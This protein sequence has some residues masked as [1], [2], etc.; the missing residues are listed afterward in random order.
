MAST[1]SSPPALRAVRTLVARGGGTHYLQQRPRRLAE[2]VAWLLRIPSRRSLKGRCEQHAHAPPIGCTGLG[3]CRATMAMRGLTVFISDLRNCS[4][5]E[6][7]EK[8]VE[9]EMAHIRSKFR[10]D[11]NMNGYNRKKYVWK[12]LYMYMLGY[13]VDFGH[14]EAV[15]LISSQRYSEKSVGYAWCALMLREGDA[16]LRLFINSIRVDLISRNDN[17]ACLALNA[18]CNVGGEE[19]A[20]TLSSNVIELLTN[21][22]TKTYVRKK[23]ALTTLRLYRKSNDILRAEEWADKIL[24]LFDEKNIGL[25][26]SVTS[27]VLGILAVDSTGWEGASNKAARTLTR[28]VLNKDYSNDYLYYGIPTPWLQIKLLRVLQHFPPPAEHALKLRVSEV[29]QK[30]ISGTEVTKNVNKNNATHAVLFEAINLSIHLGSHGQTLQQCINLLGRFI[31]IREA[32]IRYLGLETMARL[33][34]VQPETLE[35]LKKHHST[36]LFSLKD[37]DISIRRRALDL[38]YAMCDMA[39]VKETVSELLVYLAVADA[40]IKEELVLKI[41]ILSERFASDYAWYVDVIIQLIKSAGDYVADEIWYRVVQIVTNQ[42]DDLQKHATEAAWRSFNEEP[43]P[44]KTLVKVTGYILG[45]FGHMISDRP[46]S[47]PAQ[48]L[49]A[50]HRHY[51]SSEP[52]VRA[53]LLN[54]YIKLAHT[55]SEVA[56][57]VAEIMEHYSAAMDQEVQQRAAEYISLSAPGMAEIKGTVLEMMPHFTERESIVHKTLT[58]KSQ[59]EGAAVPPPRA[60]ARTAPDTPATAPARTAPAPDLLGGLDEPSPPAASSAADLLGGLDLGGVPEP[61]TA[62]SS[63]APDLLGLL[64]AVESPTL[65]AGVDLL[66][67]MGRGGGAVASTVA[68]GAP[69]PLWIALC[70]RNHGVLFEDATVQIGVKMEFQGHQGR[71]GLFFGN[72]TQ[73]PLMCAPALHRARG[74]PAPSARVVPAALLPPRIQ[75]GPATT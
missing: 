51:T 45:E 48:Q 52:E 28:L 44:H 22:F 10:S 56:P 31:S 13:E 37:P 21:N 41:A 33:S 42:G 30:I 16:L 6:Q 65:A 50:L 61:P 29:L 25:L 53:L 75:G 59:Q 24:Q 47:R 35:G 3:R 71:L 39:S 36:I 11:S 73:A 68:V 20:E 72:K 60:D 74:A 57:Q 40:G 9:K 4:T 26:T 63:A 18:I 67:G 17:A 43:Y 15:K 32:N 62:R 7:E 8:R 58:S 34:E 66:G 55:Y 69:T 12:I 5:K 23:A 27:L 2:A 1:A 19:F 64:E 38:V 46:G 70:M 14:M 49:Q 54:T